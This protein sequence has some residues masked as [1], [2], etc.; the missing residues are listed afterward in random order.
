[1]HQVL[2]GQRNA[3]FHLSRDAPGIAVVMSDIREQG[4]A[5]LL[6]GNDWRREDSDGQATRHEQ[7]C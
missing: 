7:W 5:A 2:D 3:F 1:M 4:S 6:H